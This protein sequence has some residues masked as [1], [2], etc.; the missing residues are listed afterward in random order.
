MKKIIVTLLS[1]LTTAAFAA[2]EHQTLTNMVALPTNQTVI[3][4]EG[5]FEPD[6]SGSYSIRLYDTDPGNPDTIIY[7]SGIIRPR[8]GML[9]KVQVTDIN[10]D[11]EMEII[12]LLR[13]I[14]ES[15]S[16]MADI[17]SFSDSQLK[18]LNTVSNLVADRDPL[19]Q[20]RQ[21]N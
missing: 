19:Q 18:L 10:G 5:A 7:R 4:E 13:S 8:T 9:E 11:E 12:V 20:I 3:T 16:Q 14:D 6:E 21:S 1:L 17:Y 15:N 2:D